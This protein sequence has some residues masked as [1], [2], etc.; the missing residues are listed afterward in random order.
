MTQEEVIK[1]GDGNASS[2]WREVVQTAYDADFHPVLRSA[3]ADTSLV[4]RTRWRYDAHGNV[5]SEKTAPYNAAVFTGDTLS[6]DSAGRYLLS[7]T[8]ALG[9]TTTYAGYNKFGKPLSATDYRGR[10]TSFYYDDWGNLVRTV[11]PDST[12]EQSAKVWGGDG[13]YTV[14]NTATGKPDQVAHYDALGREIKTGVKRF[15]GQWQWQNKEYD[16]KGRI[17]RV[18]LPYRGATPAYWNTYHYD[19]YDRPDT[20]REASGRLTT[21]SYNGTSTTTVQ[22]GIASTKT[23]DANGNLIRV[24]DPGGTITYSLRDDG[25]PHTVTAFYNVQTSITY[26]RFG[27]RCQINDPSA[28]IQRDTTVWYADGTSVLTHTNAKGSISTHKDRFGR[29]TFIDRPEFDTSYY[30]DNYGRLSS[31]QSTNGTRLTY[32]YDALDRISEVLDKISRNKWLKKKYCYGV[33]SVLNSVQFISP[34]DTITTERYNYANGHLTG[35]TLSNGMVVWSLVSENDLGKPTQIT[36]GTIDREY[37]YTAYGLP[38]YRYMDGSILQEFSY[39]FDAATGNLLWRQDEINFKSETFTYDS[40]N[41]LTGS[42]SSSGFS[43]YYSLKGNPAYRDDIGFYYF[44]DDDHPYQATALEVEHPNLARGRSQRITYT[45][46]DRPSRLSEGGRI[47]AFTYNADY[48][49]VRMQ[50]TDSISHATLLTR[51]YLGDRYEIDVVGNTTKERLYLGGDAYSAPMV[52]VREGGTNGTW[53]AYNIGRDYLGS[54]THIATASG[55]LVAEYSYDPWGRLR[56]PATLAVYTVGNEPDLFLGRGFTGHEHLP[57]FG[58]INMNARL[59]DPLLGRFLSPDPYVQAPDFTQSLNRYSYAL[60]NPLK[61]TDESGEFVLTTLL[62][63]GGIT[64]GIFGLGNLAAHAIRGDDLGHWNWAK[65]FFSGAVAGFVVGSLAYTGW[66]GLEA[67]S[68]LGGFWGSVGTIG[69]GV[70]MGVEGLHA[71]TTVASFMGGAITHGWEGVAN[72]G[73]ILLGN[74][75]LA[76][77]GPFWHIIAQGV[78]RH[79]WESLQT[80]VGYDYTQLKNTIGQVDRVD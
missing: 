11:Y 12:A 74:F 72:A 29:T 14:T 76:E 47:A 69:K 42:T 22:E 64:A 44:D 28:G 67:L 57:W 52:Y 65:Y 31:E 66:A 2:S 61:Y 45:S 59:Y 35:V 21:W 4:S 23:T 50:V 37:G 70:A 77:K 27:N 25:Q 36:S 24:T 51:Y 56:D 60:N 5:I 73:K 15:N 80:G 13:L 58:L 1:E 18:S 46:Y 7:K 3:F 40:L 53:T 71:T 34:T 16:T 55:T 63:V 43:G 32:T 38:T 10:T 78:L 79:T 54:I 33:G 19:Y 62:I 41:R 6:F 9:H 20:L 75:Y 26:D 30:Y 17:K 39:S 49:R 68:S 8:D 48:D